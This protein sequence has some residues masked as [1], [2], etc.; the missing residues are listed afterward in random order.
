MT[1]TD[2]YELANRINLKSVHVLGWRDL[3][4]GEAGGSELH[5]HEILK[6]FADH[7]LTVTM[8]TSVAYGHSKYGQ[9]SGYQISRK[10]SRYTVFFRSAASWL[11]HENQRS[12]ALIE[13]WNGMPFFSPV[14]ANVPRLTII[15]HVHGEMWSL[16][17]KKNLAAVGKNLEERIAPLFYK[18]ESI[19][20]PSES[21]ANELVT[22]LKLS[23]SNIHVVHPGIDSKFSPD[24]EQKSKDPLVISVGRLVP[25]KRHLDLIKILAE[26]K[27]RVDA[28]KVV[29][30]GD[31]YERQSLIDFVTENKYQDWIMLP[32]RISD[33]ELASLYRSA[34]LIVSNS[35]REGWG[36]TLV[37]A[38]ACGTPA[39][40]TEI[41]G[42][43]DSIKNKET[44]YLVKSEAEFIDKVT[45]LLSDAN[46]L[47]RLSLN[48]TK[49][50]ESCSWDLVA[51]KAI[52]LLVKNYIQKYKL[53]ISP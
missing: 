14:W 36:L 25:V 49:V 20:T 15:H 3:D 24:F 34:S 32:G 33:T 51:D 47:K 35:M 42:H 7:G 17:F 41:V 39:V 19:L 16:V 46:E 37:E 43:R 26:V 13:I 52:E 28:L 2:Y 31:G 1:D 21:T 53:N 18:R 30:A 8:R 23:E 11:A 9:R 27:G 6:R 45:Y 5:A 29:I 12:Q 48:A 38:A 4:D 10:G 50:T 44:G 40:A 22:K